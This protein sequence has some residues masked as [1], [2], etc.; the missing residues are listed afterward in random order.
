[1]N[2]K[3]IGSLRLA[4]LAGRMMFAAPLVVTRALTVALSAA[5]LATALTTFSPLFSALPDRR[6]RRGL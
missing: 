5:V 4:G 1:M 2:F 6:E 3:T